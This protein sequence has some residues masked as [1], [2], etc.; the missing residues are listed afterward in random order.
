MIDKENLKYPWMSQF[1][2]NACKCSRD[3]HLKG[4]IREYLIQGRDL[5]RRISS[6]FSWCYTPQGHDYWR[7]IEDSYND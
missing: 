6:A 5:A 1:A 3:G 2:I 7:D 4:T